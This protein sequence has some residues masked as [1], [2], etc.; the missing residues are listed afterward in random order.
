MKIYSIIFLLLIE[1]KIYSMEQT[2]H[3]GQANLWEAISLFENG[4]FTESAPLFSQLKLSSPIARPYCKFLIDKG[5]LEGDMPIEVT[6][7]YNCHK[8]AQGW[9]QVSRLLHKFHGIDLPA[10]QRPK[11]NGNL[12]FIKNQT[13]VIKKLK[14]LSDENCGPAAYAL[15]FLLEKGVPGFLTPNPNNSKASLLRAAKNNDPRALIELKKETVNLNGVSIN[16]LASFLT[17]KESTPTDSLYTLTRLYGPQ[18]KNIEALEIMFCR[19]AAY[20]GHLGAQKIMG[21][22]LSYDDEESFYWFFQAHLQNDKTSQSVLG[23][24]YEKGIGIRQNL[25]K[26]FYYASEAIKTD[27]PN[28]MPY[29]NLAVM[30]EQGIGTNIDLSKAENFFRQA[31]QSEDPHYIHILG[32][33]LKRTHRIEEGDSHIIKAAEMGDKEA[34]WNLGVLAKNEKN[35]K[36]CLAYFLPLARENYENSRSTL[37]YMIAANEIPCFAPTLVHEWLKEFTKS[38]KVEMQIFGYYNLAL[39]ILDNHLSDKEEFFLEY[40]EKAA[41]LGCTLAY[42][43][44]GNAYPKGLVTFNQAIT[45]YRKAIKEKDWESFN[46][47][48]VLLMNQKDSNLTLQENFD[49]EAVSC[50]ENAIKYNTINKINAMYNLSVLIGQERGELRLNPDRIESLLTI[51][52]KSGDPDAAYNLGVYYSEGTKG[53]PK[54]TLKAKEFFKIAMNTGHI[55]ASN[56]YALTLILDPTI[57]RQSPEYLEGMNVLK[58]LSDLGA[59]ES[60]INWIYFTILSAEYDLEEIINM[61]VS[62][63]PSNQRKLALYLGKTLQSIEKM[64]EDIE[65]KNTL[66]NI[67]IYPVSTIDSPAKPNSDN[68]DNYEDDEFDWQVYNASMAQAKQKSKNSE[69]I[70]KEKTNKQEISKDLRRTI[71]K[72]EKFSNRKQVKWRKIQAIMGKMI[73]SEGGSMLNTKGS[74]KSVSIGDNKINLDAPHGVNGSELKG[75]RLNRCLSLM[76]K[77]IPQ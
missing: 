53:F 44:I 13:D 16:S 32:K 20:H 39:L 15:S 21:E 43:L 54:D 36:T 10:T 2:D 49:K 52:M 28:P 6:K 65:N 63:T 34:Q 45:A 71:K 57:K 66:D 70:A 69:I 38:D 62:L 17:L 4:K 74:G 3:P 31:A 68:E 14:S 5:Y 26:A 11:N 55:S 23:Y 18:G 67:N 29:F 48:G 8:I 72:L 7:G 19:L 1:T 75:D 37:I 56:N 51:V 22:R 41:Q 47:L 33:F 58:K 46:A 27:D 24:M 25:Q 30:L 42:H 76:E 35:Y 60:R 59:V 50:F 9:F 12:Q 40:L 77:S 61:I 64:A 73:Q